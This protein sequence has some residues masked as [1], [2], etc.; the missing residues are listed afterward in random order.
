[1]PTIKNQVV[2]NKLTKGVYDTNVANNT[3]TSQMIED[4]VFIFTDDQHVS[5]AEKTAWNNK[6]DFSGDYN[7]LTNKPTIPTVPTKTSDL[8]NDSGFITSE[9]D[10]TVPSW[11]KASTKPSY[12]A[13]E[14]G[15]IATSDK[16][17]ANGLASLDSDGKVPTT[18]MPYTAVTKIWS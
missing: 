7:D 6:S 17:V 1:M 12:T 10:P 18:Q 4:E 15:A 14:V 13:S 5:A 16:G 3:I 11:A 8:T 2:I 9:S